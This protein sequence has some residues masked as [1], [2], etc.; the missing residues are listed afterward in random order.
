LGLNTTN[1]SIINHKNQSASRWRNTV[2]DARVYSHSCPHVSRRF[3]PPLAPNNKL[4][5]TRF[6]DSGGAAPRK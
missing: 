6:N 1:E 4:V 3:S 5:V 2:A